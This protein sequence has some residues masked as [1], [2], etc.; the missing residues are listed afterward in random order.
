MPVIAR[1]LV[2]DVDNSV[3]PLIDVDIKMVVV[4][5]ANVKGPVPVLMM[6]G[7]PSLPAPAQP[8]PED[9]EKLNSVFKE[10]MIKA[11]P[12]V[13]SIFDKYPAY[14]PV[15]RLPAPNP[16]A[17]PPAEIPPTEQLLRA[18]WGYATIDANSIQADNGA[19][20]TMGIIV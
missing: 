13:K 17:P 2:G 19:G 10:M 5:P 8:L 14:S 7:R 20:M 4:V 9:M 15:T 3:Y 11:D 16:F 1:E 6:F 12:S 18:G